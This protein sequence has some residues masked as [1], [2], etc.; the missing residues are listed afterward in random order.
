[1]ADLLKGENVGILYLYTRIQV[2]LSSYFYT[3]SDKITQF[4]SP[5]QIR[6]KD[7]DNCVSVAMYGWVLDNKKQ[8]IKQ[9]LVNDRSR[10]NGLG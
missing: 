9:F 10:Y 8:A 4:Q 6:F 1:M 5:L 3:N 7:C 2:G